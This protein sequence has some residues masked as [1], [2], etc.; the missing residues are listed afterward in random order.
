MDLGQVFTSS[1]VAKY[2]V[3]LLNISFSSSILDPCFGDGVFID[4]C[5]EAGFTNITG[6]EIDENLY[7]AVKKMPL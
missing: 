4:A 3:S 7:N 1:V 5:L 2:M 6:Y